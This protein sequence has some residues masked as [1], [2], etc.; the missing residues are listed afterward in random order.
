MSKTLAIEPVAARDL[1]EVRGDLAELFRETVNGGDTVGFLPPISSEEAAAY[2]DEVGEALKGGRRMLVARRGG[3][4]VGTVQLDLAQQTNGR[5]RA[6]VMKLLVDRGA[7]RL[8][9]GRRLMEAVEGVARDEG[10]TLLVL[11][12]RRG[13]PSEEFYAA[14]GYERA[15]V[16]PNFAE[17][18]D[19]TLHATVL[20]YKEL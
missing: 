14:L 13:E 20:F 15:G 18:A 7:R 12:T 19:G 9:L 3:R 10:R 2:W 8:G 4:V 17:S 16:I 6:E 5:H 11:D 1:P